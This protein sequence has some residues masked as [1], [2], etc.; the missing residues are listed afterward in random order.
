MADK[1]SSNKLKGCVVDDSM[2]EGRAHRSYLAAR[3]R[4][5]AQ[6]AASLADPVRCSI[7]GYFPFRHIPDRC[8]VCLSHR[9]HFK[10]A[11]SLET[12]ARQEGVEA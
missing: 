6:R 11:S 2:T 7:C 3:H 8:P 10:R 1:T 12:E 9:D 5:A 4:A